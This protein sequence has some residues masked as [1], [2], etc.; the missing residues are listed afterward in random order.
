MSEHDGHDRPDAVRGM[1]FERIGAENITQL[2]VVRS[3]RGF[4][5]FGFPCVPDC[6]PKLNVDIPMKVSVV[7]R[8]HPKFLFEA[9]SIMRHVAEPPAVGD[10]ADRATP[11]QWIFQSCAALS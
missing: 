10:V 1:I 5:L 7:A 3:L 8:R 2:S 6:L 11:L 4:Q 9:P